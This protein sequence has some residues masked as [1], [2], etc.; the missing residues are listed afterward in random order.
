MST[1]TLLAKDDGLTGVTTWLVFG[2]VVGVAGWIKLPGG[3]GT[4]AV[5][6]GEIAGTGVA[7]RADV[8]AVGLG[9]NVGVAVGVIVAV[10]ASV[11]AAVV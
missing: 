4:M 3:V 8:P 11:G 5:P 9:V 7:A 6:V 1:A 2:A 10:R